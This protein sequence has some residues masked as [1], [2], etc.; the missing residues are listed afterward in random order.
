MA[1]LHV[2]KNGGTKGMHGEIGKRMSKGRDKPHA[3]MLPCTSA[4]ADV[5]SRGVGAQPRQQLKPA[6][7]RAGQGSG[8]QESRFRGSC[9]DGC[10]RQAWQG[11][12]AAAVRISMHQLHPSTQAAT[13]RQCS[14]IDAHRMSR[15]MFMA[16]VWILKI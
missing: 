16:R 5:C 15:S 9:R 14:P 10:S 7:G 1:L 4:P 11:G 6:G 8:E 3:Q 13:Q 12:H 2:S